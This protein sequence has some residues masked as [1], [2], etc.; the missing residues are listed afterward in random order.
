M[1]LTFNN[2]RI[3]VVEDNPINQMLVGHTLQRTGAIVDFAGDGRSATVRIREH[4]YDVVLMDIQLPEMDGFEATYF[5]RNEIQSKVP[6]I[7][8]TAMMIFDEEDK[9]TKCG[10]NN[11][12]L[13][14]FTLEKFES[15]F[16]DTYEKINEQIQHSDLLLGDAE[17]VIDL[18]TLYSFSEDKT[19]LKQVVETFLTTLPD[20]IKKMEVYSEMND[21]DNLSRMAHFTKSSLSVIKIQQILEQVQNIEWQCR[22]GS[23]LETL[24][25]KINYIKTQY[26]VAERLLLEKFN[27]SLSQKDI[28]LN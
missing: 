25:E 1:S 24:P 2:K 19:Y 26:P 5:I 14:P 17:L 10:M 28:T 23:S 3:L 21:Y 16:T 18:A 22:T 6:I 8:M 15:I 4:V 13:K 9:C 11:C 7:G 27:I 12:L 20:S